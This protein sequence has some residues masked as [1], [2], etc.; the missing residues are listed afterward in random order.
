DF[1]HFPYDLSIGELGEYS[2]LKGVVTD[3]VEYGL[4]FAH[5]FILGIFET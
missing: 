5:G 4:V 1:L 3:E 2:G